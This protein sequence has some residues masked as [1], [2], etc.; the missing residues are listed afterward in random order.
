ME[1][2]KIQKISAVLWP[3][4][5]AAGLAT[6][7]TFSVF[8]PTEILRCVGGPEIDRLGAYTIGFFFFWLVTAISSGVS[9]YFVRCEIPP[10]ASPKDE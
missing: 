7:I 2:P 10:R 3:S 6:A 9:C 5:L 8:D 4:F 1:I